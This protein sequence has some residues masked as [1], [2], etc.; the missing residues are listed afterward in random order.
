MPHGAARTY[1]DWNATAPLCAP[2]RTAMLEAL[3]AAN[4]S[5]VHAEGRAARAAV[6]TARRQVAALLGAE[7]RGVVFTSG[8]TE[9]NG[10]ALTPALQVEGDSRPRDGLA[11]S[12]I[13]HP[14]VL[15]GHRFAPE[16]V[17]TIA[18]DGEG[19][20]TPELVA[21]ALARLAGRG[22]TRQLV[23]VTL[24]S[25]ETG[26]IQPIAEIAALVH[27]VDGLLHVD[28]VQAAGRIPIDIKALGADLLTVSSHKLGGPKGA[29][30]LVLA[31]AR[32]HIADTL[33]RGGG[34]ERGLRAGTEN[35]AAIAGF[36]AA[37]DH[38][39]ATLDS[40]PARQRALR[41]RLADGLLAAPGAVLIG[42]GAPRLPN[43]VLVGL[44]G[45]AAETAVIAFDLAGVSVSAGAACSSGKVGPSH[46]VSAMGRDDLARSAI[47]LSLGR[48]TTETDVDRAIAVWHDVASALLKSRRGKAA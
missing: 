35:V 6:E 38:A 29:G 11:M 10:L 32:L 45:L 46:V 47:R 14:S 40:E 34:Q 17:E 39:R 1:L 15:R 33:L 3:D 48:D 21:A 9:A 8:A 22:R 23:S 31:S 24:A 43:T 13:E 44:P 7:P 12:A 41:D 5:S 20:A 27:A 2:A 36:G 37:C 30:A 42:A 25:N 26:V 19:V 16:A 28:A 4:P 18:V